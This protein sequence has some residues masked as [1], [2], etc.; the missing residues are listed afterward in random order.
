MSRE[1]IAHTGPMWRWTGASGN[2]TWHFLTLDG[3]AGEALSG[4]ALMRKLDGMS[5]GWGSLKVVATIGKS[6]WNTSVFP[7]KETGWILPVK[8]AVRKAEELVE[9]EAVEVQLELYP[10]T[11]APAQAGVQ[12]SSPLKTGWED[13]PP[14]GP[15]PSPG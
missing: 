6:R 15:R 12:P 13:A 5:R 8:A 1:T 2:G 4:T 3:K 14:D 9:G 7:S 11:V 10:P